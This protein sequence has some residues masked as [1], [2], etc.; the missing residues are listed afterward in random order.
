MVKKMKHKKDLIIV[1]AGP[2]GMAAA[3]T[4][5]EYGLDVLVLDEQAAPGGQIYRNL[6]RVPETRFSILGK[7]YQAGRDLVSRF[8]LCNADYEPN[9]IV[10]KIDPR[11]RVCFSKGGASR[12][13]AAQSVLIATGAVERPVPFPGW[14]LPGVMGA[15]AMDANFK[16]SGIYP[17][18]PV[19][20][21]GSGPLLLL[22]AT[23]LLDLGV[24]IAGI[25]ETT[26]WKNYGR[27]LGRVGGALRRPGYLAKGLG[28]VARLKGAGIP[29]ISRVVSYAAH[30]G[31][32]HENSAQEG[33]R[34]QRVSYETSRKKGE[35]AATSL[36][37]HEGIVPRCDFTRQLSLAHGWDPVQRYWYPKT[38]PQGRTQ[39][40]C[41]HVAGDTA[42]V[43][44]GVAAALKG[45][46]AAID[47]AM[48][49]KGPSRNLDRDSGRD[50]DSDLAGS[51]HERA[52]APV[53]KKL[54]RELFPRP[55][56]DQIYAPRRELYDLEDD[57]LVCRC[58]GVVAGDI[59]RALA[60]GYLDINAVK[61]VTRCGMGPCQGR[62]CGMALAEIIAE[63]RGMDP[64]GISPLTIRPP[65]RNLSLME[66]ADAQLEGE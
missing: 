29:W 5:K 39:E 46:L 45:E 27:A 7:D 42:F 15:G 28:L 37:V 26:P 33:D 61:G 53:Y 30:G 22:T 52:A 10:W 8:R 20:L 9:A 43:H 12:E 4:A 49:L 48:Q 1:G 6:D 16:S 21:A 56:V 32:D 54:A 40:L 65:V 17:Q 64:G 31:A 38:T 13:V 50:L 57:V 35:F 25:L 34:L 24:K 19:V 60:Q 11:G 47:I 58:E 44:G 2:S 36:L 51:A 3:V 23:H 59:R 41:I 18:G 14:T 63:H 62:M 55:F 66:L